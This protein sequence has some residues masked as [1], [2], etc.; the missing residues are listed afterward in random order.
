MHLVLVLGDVGDKPMPRI[1]II[2]KL[3]KVLRNRPTVIEGV[4]EIRTVW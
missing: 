3:V 1:R 4:P 2:D